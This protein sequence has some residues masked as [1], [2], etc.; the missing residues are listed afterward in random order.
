MK[1]NMKSLFCSKSVLFGAATLLLAAITAPSAQVMAPPYRINCGGP[2]FTDT[3]GNEWEADSHYTGGDTYVTGEQISMTEE[4]TLYQTERWFDPARD[5]LKYDFTV[6]NGSYIVRMHMAEIYAPWFFV[7]SRVFNIAINDVAVAENYDIFAEV[8]GNVASIKEYPVAVTTG[9]I[10]IS[11][12][13]I[14]EHAKVN[15]IEVFDASTVHSI[16]QGK[17][18]NFLNIKSTGSAITVLSTFPSSYSVA[19][20]DITGS[21]LDQ[22]SGLGAGEQR[23]NNLRP[24]VYFVDAKSGSKMFTKKVCVLP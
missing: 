14:A 23:F 20:R 6:P 4:G 19:L 16:S 11:F 1:G 15:A 17:V 5:P 3:K 10:S 2:A 21:K 8:G 12:T 24:G 22:K 9:A 18:N 7:G 13:N